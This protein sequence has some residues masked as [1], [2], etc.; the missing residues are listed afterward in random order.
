[1]LND[2]HH[3]QIR[4]RGF[5]EKLISKFSG[6]TGEQV[7][8]RSLEAEEI[9]G[10][11]LDQFPKMKGNQHGA[12]LLRFNEK[13][14]SMRPDNLVVDEE[15]VKYLYVVR[16]TREPKGSN[17]QPWIPAQ[18]PTIATEGLFDALV[19]TF[20][21]ETPCAGVTAP[22]HIKNSDLP[23]SVSV[24][25]NDADVP[26]HHSK[27]FLGMVIGQCRE[28]GLKI[29]HLPCN[30]SAKYAYTEAK[31]P[32]ICKWGMEEW[33]AE[34]L[35]QGL[36]P[37]SQLANIVSSAQAPVDYLKSIF[38]EYQDLGIN[39]P[40]HCTIIENGARAIFDATISEPERQLLCGLLKGCTNAPIGWIKRI[41]ELRRQ[42]KNSS[43][44][45][46]QQG[47]AVEVQNF[48]A[49]GKPTK[50][51]L[52][53]FL[54]SKYKIRFNEL[55]GRVELDDVPMHEIDLADQWLAQT[56]KIEVSDKAAK[57][58]FLY[59]GKCNPYNPV[60]EYF[61]NLRDREDLVLV[62]GV[63]LAQAFGIASGD[64]LS[65]ELLARH[66]VGHVK[67]GMNPSG[68]E[69]R[70][71]AM[72]ILLGR[73]GQ[74]KS[75]AIQALA[76]NDWY[77]S[78]T[79]VPKLE[80]W[81]FL[82][83]INS[84]LMFEFDECERMIRSK[85]ASEFKGFITRPVDKYVEKH[86]S[87]SKDHPRKSC[88]WGTTNEHDL[89]SDP[90]GSRRFWIVELKSKECDPDWIKE[91]RDSIWASVM[92]WMEWGLNN[93]INEKSVTAQLA[94]RRAYQ[95]S[96]SDPLEKSLRTAL[97]SVESYCKQGVS[98]ATLIEKHLRIDPKD[99][100]RMRSLQ[101]RITRIITSVHFTTHDGMV[102]WEPKKARFPDL[103]IPGPLSTA[104]PLAGYVP[105]P[106]S[107]EPL[108]DLDKVETPQMP[109]EMNELTSLFQPLQQIPRPSI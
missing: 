39:Y 14:L 96:H 91:N 61:G 9:Q 52:Q 19:S 65:Q 83:R 105:V 60:A 68:E 88:L 82:P 43:A 94:A 56:H 53:E 62:S 45:Q 75:S 71:H 2:N 49:T 30:P 31:I 44:L 76:P 13:T 108:L 5:D 42:N 21:M 84:A 86:Q 64:R 80:D 107:E 3:D 92:T 33:N 85:T 48:K 35:K 22:S 38:R 72:L 20:L 29:A 7:I 41:I 90:T 26:F 59:L 63:D 27:G 66:L 79:E 67:R 50:S 106:T 1:M 51:E 78:A 87:V 15:P 98:Q 73:Q 70:H 77:D 6:E 101:M 46:L 89:L 24:Y 97:E 100:D 23:P 95:Y 104:P 37:K 55:T 18:E 81:N 102:R 103:A 58:T 109:W 69:A 12:L 36:D 16:E 32:A 74:M 25:I 57:S 93:W 34:W 4:A 10:K 54:T 47:L 28:K 8:L 17:T 40:K 11:W 99:C